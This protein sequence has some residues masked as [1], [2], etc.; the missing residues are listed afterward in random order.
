MDRLRVLIAVALALGVVGTG[1]RGQGE[2]EGEPAA[3]GVSAVARP[4]PRVLERSIAELDADD[5]TTRELATERL[6]QM[7]GLTLDDVLTRLFEDGALTSEQRRRLERVAVTQFA[8]FPKAG[9]GVG[10]GRQ[11]AGV[12]VEIAQVVMPEVFPAAAIL[13]VGDFITHADGRPVRSADHLRAIILSHGVGESMPARLRRG[14]E[15][16]EVVLPL[17]DYAIL[18]RAGR[19]D[20]ATA[21]TAVRERMMRLGSR[22]PVAA[23]GEGLTPEA[24]AA[25]S[26][27]DGLAGEGPHEDEVVGAIV[28]GTPRSNPD[29][30]MAGAPL[31]SL[32]GHSGP[33]WGDLAA[34][35]PEQRLERYIG[36]SRQHERVSNQ[37]LTFRAL[38]DDPQIAP[39][40]GDAILDRIR[41][42][43]SEQ[44]RLEADMDALRRMGIDP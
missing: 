38:H 16:L 37:I 30:G 7:P 21:Q 24:W 13:R 6:G 34:L 29:T 26:E 1:A 44:R 19:I 42:L 20:D 18:E 8:R 15:E 31:W 40:D 39:G 2:P 41:G 35:S 32:P 23:I 4:D 3:R 22:E 17:G 28:G 11:I 14:E 33:T 25:V 9:L 5:L 36:L 43:V 10:F 12:G 27:G